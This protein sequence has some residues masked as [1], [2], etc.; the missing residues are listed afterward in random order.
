MDD[1]RTIGRLA[2][3]AAVPVS[4]VRYYERRGLLRP[5]RRSEGN[6]RLYGLEALDRLRFVRSAQSAGFT[7][8]DIGKL[9]EFRNGEPAPCQEVQTLI[10]SR[11]D[12][13]GAQV[14]Q[15]LQV[16]EMLRQWLRVCRRAE[17][18]GR[19]GVLEGLCGCE[20]KNPRKAPKTA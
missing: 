12:S 1:P 7:L 8:S 4:T 9:L 19:C 13:V 11:L 6:Y 20:E 5:D 17:R 14:E 10:V 16:R 15:L 2:R 3:A 18:T